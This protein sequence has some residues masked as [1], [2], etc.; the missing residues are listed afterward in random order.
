MMMDG[1]T[2]CKSETPTV[3]MHRLYEN[4]PRCFSSRST[5]SLRSAHVTSRRIVL[6]LHCVTSNSASSDGIAR[7]SHRVGITHNDVRD[8]TRSVGRVSHAHWSSHRCIRVRSAHSL[9]SSVR[10]QCPRRLLQQAHEAMQTR[11]ELSCYS[12]SSLRVLCVVVWLH[13]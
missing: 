7:H 13:R 2:D 5:F 8:S 4:P 10:S 12:H 11:S 3:S 9:R 6:Y 1:R